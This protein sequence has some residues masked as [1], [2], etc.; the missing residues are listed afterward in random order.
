MPDMFKDNMH[1]HKKVQLG[2]SQMAMTLIITHDTT[3]EEIPP[4]RLGRLTFDL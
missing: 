3:D 4:K 1:K 2:F